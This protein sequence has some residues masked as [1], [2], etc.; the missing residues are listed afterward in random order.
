MSEETDIS[1]TVVLGQSALVAF[2]C[3]VPGSFYRGI[4][5]FI[6]SFLPTVL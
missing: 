3:I 6:H 2:F 5:N 1:V 4:S